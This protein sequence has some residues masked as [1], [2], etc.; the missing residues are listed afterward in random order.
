MKVN[1]SPESKFGLTTPVTKRTAE[2]ASAAVA[3]TA[4]AAQTDGARVRLSPVT[5]TMT[6]GVA[7]AATDSFDAAKVEAV[8][9]AI[10]NGSFSI[11][12]EAIADKMLSQARELLGV[13]AGGARR[14][15]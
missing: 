9:T 2:G 11:N 15:G 1:N 12:A 3:D 5:Q 14:P 6:N 7:R 4:R 10:Q 13:A 8:R